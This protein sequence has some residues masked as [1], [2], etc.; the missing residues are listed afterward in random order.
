M[1][2]IGIPLRQKKYKKTD[3]G[4][5]YHLLRKE[6]LDVIIEHGSISEIQLKIKLGI[7]DGMFYQR[8]L[9]VLALYKNMIEYDKPTKT[10]F[11]KKSD[12]PITTE[13]E[14]LK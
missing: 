1:H 10:Y 14:D 4:E 12:F 11:H 2:T 8:K 13:W 7:G 5:K 6:I 9:E 3:Y